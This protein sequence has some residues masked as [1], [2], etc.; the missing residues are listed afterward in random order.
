[1]ILRGLELPPK[2]TFLDV[3]DVVFCNLGLLDMPSPTRAL[4]DFARVAKPGGRILATLPLAGSWQEFHDLFR[5]VLV[6][7][8]QLPMIERLDK[9]CDSMPDAA[10]CEG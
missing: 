2:A 1:M 8:D 3:F 10:T 7:N 6:K 9:L 5:E 4:R